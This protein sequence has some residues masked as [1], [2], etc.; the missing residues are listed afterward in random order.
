MT[1]IQV[2]VITGSTKGIGYGVAEEL[3]KRGQQVVISGHRQ[4]TLDRA[5]AT[6][7]ARYGD[8]VAGCLCDVTKPE[9]HER[10]WA[11]ACARFGRVDIW[12]N[13]AGVAHPQV[14][15]W[16][17]PLDK[18]REVVEVNVLGA[19]YG[20]RVA[21]R[22]ML[23]QGGGRIYNLEGFGADGRVRAGLTIYGMSKAAAAYL[24]R[25]L[26]AELQGTPVNLITVQPGMVI[27]DLVTAQFERPEDLERVKPIFNI[28]A[29]RVSEVAPWLAEHLLRPHA[30]GARLEFLPRHKML[31]RFASALVIRR[32]VFD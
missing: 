28:I 7:A 2:V 14:K 4:E 31:W 15:A 11:F 18:V 27:T 12:V 6:L 8:N 9:D 20:T 3:L 22:G 30:N 1:L 25:S 17:L 5:L 16:M 29:S 10:L 21:V 32:H 24:G 26:A 13:N 19:Y 23:E